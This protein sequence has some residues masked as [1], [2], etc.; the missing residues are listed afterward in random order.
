MRGALARPVEIPCL[1]P[2]QRILAQFPGNG[3]DGRQGI[4]PEPRTAQG[5]Y[6]PGCRRGIARSCGKR[7]IQVLAPC[8]EV[9]ASELRIREKPEQVRPLAERFQGIPCNCPGTLQVTLS[10]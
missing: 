2:H 4:P 5:P 1:G 8:D 3:L 6:L 9:P 10:Q 7:L